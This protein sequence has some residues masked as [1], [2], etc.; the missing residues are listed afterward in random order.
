LN[1]EH[2]DHW[3]SVKVG[4]NLG[5][6][7]PTRLQTRIPKVQKWMFIGYF[8]SEFDGFFLMNS[9]GNPFQKKE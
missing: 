7:H 8:S 4:I 9:L 1:F 2:N 5:Y 6:C 3:H